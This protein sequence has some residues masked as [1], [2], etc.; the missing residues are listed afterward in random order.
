MSNMIIACHLSDPAS[1]TEPHQSFFTGDCVCVFLL[2]GRKQA[3]DCSTSAEVNIDDFV[4][5]FDQNPDVLVCLLFS[6]A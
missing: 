6:F 3:V 1:A 4:C 2:R 5:V